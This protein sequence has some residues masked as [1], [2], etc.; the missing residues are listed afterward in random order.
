MFQRRIMGLVSYYIGATP[1]YY[2]SK[3]INYI[4]PEEGIKIIKN[5]LK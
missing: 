3:T 4:D 5:N 2:A 1:D